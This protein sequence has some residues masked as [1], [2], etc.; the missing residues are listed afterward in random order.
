[1]DH[2]APALTATA[3][4]GNGLDDFKAYRRSVMWRSALIGAAALT[5]APLIAPGNMPLIRGLLLGFGFSLA[6][7]RL[8]SSALIVF[9]GLEP[10]AAQAFMVQRR[11]LTLGLT[12]A[13]LAIAFWRE[14]IL[15][16]A[17]VG[18]LFLTTA[19]ILADAL[20]RGRSEPPSSAEDS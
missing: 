4:L 1:M 7:F 19:V 12:A 10:A 11:F 15:S 9:P 3:A 17:T 16:W 20:L 5:A 6:K 8:A 2:A 18:G 14:E 13:V